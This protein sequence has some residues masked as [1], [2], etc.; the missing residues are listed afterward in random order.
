MS[1]SLDSSRNAR[2]HRFKKP[3][4]SEINVTPFVDVMLVLLV[5]FMVTA[6]MLTVSVPVNLPHVRGAAMRETKE[7]L[8]VTINRQGELFI[9]DRK[10]DSK[11]LV[12]QLKAITKSTPQA[13]IY[14]RGDQRIHYGAVMQLMSQ[15]QAAGFQHV[16]LVASHVNAKKS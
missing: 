11:N 15:L 9:Q 1:F 8:T 13:K 7:P 10:V 12:P 14:V 4:M 6:P 5:V 16:G 3:L 2:R